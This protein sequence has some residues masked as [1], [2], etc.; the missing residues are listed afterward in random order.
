MFLFTDMGHKGKMLLS[1]PFSQATVKMWFYLSVPEKQTSILNLQTSES[2]LY[3]GHTLTN[4]YE[5]GIGYGNYQIRM[6]YYFTHFQRFSGI[7][8][9]YYFVVRASEGHRK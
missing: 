4:S 3:L 8:R 6:S 1:I 7:L 5:R 9:M 2:V